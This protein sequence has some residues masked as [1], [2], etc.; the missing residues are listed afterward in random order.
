MIGDRRSVEMFLIL[1]SLRPNLIL[2]PVGRNHGLLLLQG[3]E[4]SGHSLK[5]A[6]RKIFMVLAVPSIG[7]IHAFIT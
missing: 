1:N 3:S 6:I 5:G 2:K 4:R 7:Q